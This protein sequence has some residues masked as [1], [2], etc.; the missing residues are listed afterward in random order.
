M[1]FVPFVVSEAGGGR[2]ASVENDWSSKAKRTERFA[3]LL[4]KRLSACPFLFPSGRSRSPN[5]IHVLIV[6]GKGG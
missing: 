4:F 1:V 2:P 6:V 5:P 3:D